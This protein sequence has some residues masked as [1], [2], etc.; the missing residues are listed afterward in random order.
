MNK[1][2]WYNNCAIYG[3]DYALNILTKYVDDGQ[4]ED[5]VPNCTARHMCKIASFG[6]EGISIDSDICLTD[7]LY[8]FDL[9]MKMFGNYDYNKD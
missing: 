1:L 4:P 3:F 5:F 6:I 9:Y 7:T 8:G 2:T